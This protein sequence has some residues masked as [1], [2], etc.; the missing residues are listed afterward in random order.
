LF[1]SFKS[2]KIIIKNIII[3]FLPLL[4][5]SPSNKPLSFFLK[6]LRFFPS[7]NWDH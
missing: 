6:F 3:Y 2:I 7:S 4:F 5:F 1:H